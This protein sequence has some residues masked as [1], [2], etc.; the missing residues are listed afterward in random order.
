MLKYESIGEL[1]SAAEAQGL[2]ISELVLRDQAEAMEQPPEEL[3]ER[4]RESVAV[5]RE[6]VTAVLEMCDASTLNGNIDNL[7]WVEDELQKK[8]ETSSAT[9]STSATR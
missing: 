2:K 5:M 3:Y 8:A 4:M 1:V 7:E 9:S 6:A